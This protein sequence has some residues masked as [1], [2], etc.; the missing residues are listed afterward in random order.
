[1]TTSYYTLAYFIIARFDHQQRGLMLLDAHVEGGQ[2]AAVLLGGIEQH[3]L[4]HGDS[5]GQPGPQREQLSEGITKFINET[6]KSNQNY[7]LGISGDI[8]LLGKKL[9]TINYN[10]KGSKSQCLKQLK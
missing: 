5:H 4:V 3:G 7:F 2:G 6:C 10:K 8:L 9:T 1:M